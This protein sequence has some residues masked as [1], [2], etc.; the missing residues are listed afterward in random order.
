MQEGER[1]E[2]PTRGAAVSTVAEAAPLSSL[3]HRYPA[4]IPLIPVIPFPG[5]LP[6]SPKN[7]QDPPLAAASGFRCKPEVGGATAGG[8]GGT[9]SS[10]P[11]GVRGVVPP[12][13]AMLWG[14]GA[15]I[16]LMDFLNQ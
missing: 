1:K 6:D 11:L 14:A 4:L 10:P 12:S 2:L 15:R 16:N 5:P 9:R 13:A 8:A 3:S 7:H